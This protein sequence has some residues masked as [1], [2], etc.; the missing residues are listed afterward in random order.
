MSEATISMDNFDEEV[1]QS[2]L[3]MLIDFWAPWCGPCRMIA[4]L[5]A[6]IAAEYEGRLK[7]GKVNVDEED[8]LATRHGITSI[9]CLVV[10]KDGKIAGKH[11][12][13]APKHAVEAL[14]KDML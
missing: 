10:Y 12:G 4:P 1:L 6:D 9:P 2:P 8:E 5:I 3:P 7:V 11:I 13:A 14:F